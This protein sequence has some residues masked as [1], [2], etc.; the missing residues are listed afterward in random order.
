MLDASADNTLESKA[1]S[2]NKDEAG[3]Q[4]T[5]KKPKDEVKQQTIEASFDTKVS[6][7][8][9]PGDRTIVAGPLKKAGTQSGKSQDSVKLSQSTD[10]K[11]TKKQHIAP[12]GGGSKIDLKQFAIYEEKPPPVVHPREVSATKPDDISQKKKH[13]LTTGKKMRSEHQVL[14]A[15]TN[16]KQTSTIETDAKSISVTATER[17]ILNY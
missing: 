9:K 10:K 3:V 7:E 12:S 5:E 14:K 16:L 13:I 6:V 1:T 8:A 15:N 4:K 11:S 17:N 2:P